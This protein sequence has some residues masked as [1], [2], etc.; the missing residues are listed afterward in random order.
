[1]LVCARSTVAYRNVYSAYIASDKVMS[2]LSTEDRLFGSAF[3]KFLFN[4]FYLSGILRRRM[5]KSP[6]KLMQFLPVLVEFL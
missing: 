1:M 3:S 6:F 4:L 5:P 2:L